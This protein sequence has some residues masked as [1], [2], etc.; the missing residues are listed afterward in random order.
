MRNLIVKLI[1]DP[2][3]PPQFPLILPDL[4]IRL[5]WHIP[6][7]VMVEVE[8]FDQIIS[9]YILGLQFRLQLLFLSWLPFAHHLPYFLLLCVQLIIDNFD[10]P[11]SVFDY[12]FQPFLL[13]SGVNRLH[14]FQPSLEIVFG[15]LQFNIV[16]LS[17]YLQ[18]FHLVAFY[19][20][21]GI[22]LV[23][24]SLAL[25]LQFHKSDFQLMVL[26]IFVSQFLRQFPDLKFLLLEIILSISK[27]ILPIPLD[28]IFVHLYIFGQLVVVHF[29]EGQFM[30]KFDL[31]LDQFFVI[32][33]D[34]L[35]FSCKFS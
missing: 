30:F 14:F 20:F 26:P 6:Q 33:L 27:S 12:S 9:L 3:F 24:V 11:L 10:F 34:L 15:L 19:V 25:W 18:L 4:L 7:L 32:L 28:D 35:F 8:F 17:L 31:G 23:L 22:G 13:E 5:N 29:G 21:Y 2:I 1:N 16:F